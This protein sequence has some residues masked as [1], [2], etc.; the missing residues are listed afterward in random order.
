VLLGDGRAGDPPHAAALRHQPPETVVGFERIAAGGDEVQHLLENIV[1]KPGVRRGGP[2]LG[3]QFGLLERCRAGE[4]EDVLRQHVERSG[5]ERLGIKLAIVHRVERRPR[6]QIFEA[7]AGHDHALARLVEAMVGPAD[8]LE[9]AG[10]ALGRA[11]LYDEI[12]VAPIDAEIETRRGDEPAKLARRHRA[13]DLAPRFKREA[14][15]VDADRQRL[16]VDRPQVLEDQLGE[17]ARVA[18]DEG[19]A[20][21]IDQVQDFACRMPAR[22]ARP[23]DAVFGDQDRQIGL[24]AGIA[25]HQIDQLLV[26][27]GRQPAPIGIRLADGRRQADPAELRRDLLQPGHRQ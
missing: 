21:A 26:G 9:E 3:Q 7:V 4:R 22:V 25:Q 8:P 5:T 16:V 13:L 19:R 11:H 2:E 12:D 6:L 17:A 15:V 14:A 10:A 23:G 24:G 18:E 20:V 1:E 27:I